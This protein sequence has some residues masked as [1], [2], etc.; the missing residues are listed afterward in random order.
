MEIHQLELLHKNKTDTLEEIKTQVSTWIEVFGDDVAVENFVKLSSIFVEKGNIA[1]I[2][3]PIFTGVEFEDISYD[4]FLTPL[5]V[6]RA[7]EEIKKMYKIIAELRI[8]EKQ[9]NLLRHELIITTQRVNL[10]EKVKIPEAENS[11]RMIRIYMGDQQTA[12][13]VRGKIAKNKIKRA[14]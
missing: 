13:V 8:L 7:I 14:T 2:D 9:I 11:I 5:W 3:I 4:L 1:G 6:D 10:F 12:A